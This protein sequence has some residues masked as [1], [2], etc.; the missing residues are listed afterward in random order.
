MDS[1]QENGG[2][3]PVMRLWTHIAE[4]QA[5]APRRLTPRRLG[6]LEAVSAPCVC[7]GVETRATI[8]V[9][10]AIL[11]GPAWVARRMVRGSVWVSALLALPWRPRNLR[12]ALIEMRDY[13]AV[14]MW[15]PGRFLKEGEAPVDHKRLAFGSAWRIAAI[16]ARLGFGD[17][18]R[19]ARHSAWD[20]SCAEV[21]A[22]AVCTAELDRSAEFES[23]A[24][25]E[26]LMEA[27][28]NG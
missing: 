4:I 11:F 15:A 25:V 8:A 17:P 23:R 20:A 28:D 22:H 1:T 2:V 12:E 16:A 26:E 24:E 9:E 27:Q 14:E 3:R 6:W 10:R 13:L 19:N 5:E 7:G 21:L 18:S